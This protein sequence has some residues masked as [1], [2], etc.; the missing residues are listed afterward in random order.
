MFKLVSWQFCLGVADW[1]QLRSESDSL[2]IPQENDGSIAGASL[3]W[4][5]NN[6]V[7]SGLKEEIWVYLNLC[8]LC[9]CLVASSLKQEVPN[10]PLFFLCKQNWLVR[11]Y[12]LLHT[13]QGLQSHSIP[14]NIMSFLALTFCGRLVEFLFCFNMF[15]QWAG[16]FSLP[17]L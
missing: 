15:L 17:I 12:N 3:F 6:P 8:C 1:G 16:S 13:N 11:F 7:F 9:F 4:Y 5:G 10:L 2:P 14:N